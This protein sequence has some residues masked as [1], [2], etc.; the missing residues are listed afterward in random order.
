MTVTEDLQE[1]TTLSP[2]EAFTVLGNETRVQI[3]R[4]LGEADGPLS[5]TELRDRVGIRRGSQFNYHLDKVVGHFVRKQEDGYDLRQAGRRV[6]QA[7]L[8][9]AVT[10][11]PVMERT[12]VDQPCRFCGSA[13]EVRY[14]EG[15]VEMYCV[16]CAGMSD[17]GSAGESGYLGCLMLPPAGLQTRSID[18]AFRAAWT[19]TRLSFFAIAHGLCP[20]CSATLDRWVEV[21]EDHEPTP[22]LCPACDRRNA[23]QLNFECSNCIYDGAGTLDVAVVANTD[24][25][26]FLTARGLNPISPEQSAAVGRVV[27]DYEETVQSTEPF[28]GTLRF[29]ADGETLTL[30]VDEDLNVT[31]TQ[32]T[33]EASAGTSL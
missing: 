18:E 6:V 2:A 33:T 11:A 13:I 16:E 30:L 31:R 8:S 29:S 15:H 9:E 24:L 28:A 14:H 7:V 32:P 19:W 26:A 20:H 21:C 1:P 23:V 5:F 25:L 10:D 3:L 17:S 27:D 4:T 12:E 22:G